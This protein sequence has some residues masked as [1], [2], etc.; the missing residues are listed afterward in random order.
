MEN[1][2]RLIVSVISGLAALGVAGLEAQQPKQSDT[3]TDR[4]T[5][6]CCISSRDDC[7]PS[8][9][10]S[11]CRMLLSSRSDSAMVNRAAIGVQLSATGTARD[12]LGVFVSRVT[13]K[14]PA[15]RAGI[16]EGDRLVS[17]NGVD[18]RV[19][20]ADAEDSFAAGLASRRVTREVSKLKPGAIVNVRVNSGGRIREVQVTAGRASDLREGG[21]L[22]LLDG[23]PSGVFRTMPNLEGMRAP[24]ERLRTEM[25][26]IRM[27]DFD[28]PRA[29][30]EEMT[31]PRMRIE[32]SPR[33]RVESLP[34]VW[35]D[36]VSGIRVE[37]I[38]GLRDGEG[39]IRIYTPRGDGEYRTYL[40]T[41]DGELKLDNSDRSK[42][43]REK[44]E[45]KSKK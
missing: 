34:R 37:T 11:D 18:L 4:E 31:I 14:G 32:S 2:M 36:G 40:I 17:V 10:K 30:L 27:Q 33:L 3:R 44:I 38:P 39:R 13:P 20:A 5:W 6:P 45:K 35:V 22:G 12:T 41:P 26:R 9:G 29:R 15:E 43:E 21:F 25:P 19:S 23:A 8:D 7:R 16:V 1:K 42:H 24:L 28:A